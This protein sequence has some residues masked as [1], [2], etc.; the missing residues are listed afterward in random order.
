VL[1][2]TRVLDR[3]GDVGAE[4]PQDGFVHARELVDRV[5]EQ[6]EGANHPAF[7]AQRHDEL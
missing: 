1:E 5:A 3:H 6:I 4:L 7:A 2:Q